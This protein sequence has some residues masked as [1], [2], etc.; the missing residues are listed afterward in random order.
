MH[1]PEA[2][3]VEHLSLC[4]LLGHMYI[5]F[6]KIPTQILCPLKLSGSLF[7]VRP[8]SAPEA[9]RDKEIFFTRVV[10]LLFSRLVMSSSW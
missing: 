4:V 8:L 10:L 1:F 2:N 6:R 7:I 5:V 9:L 3:D